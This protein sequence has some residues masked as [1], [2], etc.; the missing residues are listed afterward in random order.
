MKAS[1]RGFVAPL[2]LILIAVLLV[3]GGAYVYEQGKQGGTL[4]L[5]ISATETATSTETATNVSIKPISTQNWKTVKS[6]QGGFS[7]KVPAEFKQTPTSGDLIERGIDTLISIDNSYFKTL[8]ITGQITS[9]WMMETGYAGS[10]CSIIGM[11]PKGTD[12]SPITVSINGTKYSKI[13][14]S[15]GC[16]AGRCGNEIRY[17]QTID[18]QTCRYVRFVNTRSNGYGAFDWTPQEKQ[19][20]A[21]NDSRVDTAMQSLM[22]QILSTIVLTPTVAVSEEWKTYTN[23]QYGFSFNYP[24]YLGDVKIV[25]TDGVPYCPYMRTYSL[26]GTLEG[27]RTTITFTKN[28][29]I[30][31]G[32]SYVTFSI[33]V[34]QKAKTNAD[35]CGNNLIKLAN[36]FANDTRYVATAFSQKNSIKT[37]KTPL[38][39]S[40]NT[41][42][43]VLYTLFRDDGPNITVLQPIVY[44]IPYA[45][46]QEGTWIEQHSDAGDRTSVLTYVKESQTESAKQIKWYLSDLEQVVQSIKFLPVT[47]T[48]SP[49]DNYSSRWPDASQMI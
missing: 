46:T 6:E 10:G 5:I 30:G 29:S 9:S 19:L 32:G 3:C 20:A 48:S 24:S 40:I 38:A 43:T 21:E 23:Y 13:Y 36:S 28:I 35:L 41:S 42:A 14:D 16:G 31:S 27:V 22:T 44:F 25:T 1:Q 8:G 15:Q 2:I 39:T 4:P 33:P 47:Q 18:E 37:Y 7:F 34:V 45:S 49:V 17:I 11:T 12:T 26:P